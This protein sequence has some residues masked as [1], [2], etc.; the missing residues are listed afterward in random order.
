VRVLTWDEQDFILGLLRG[1]AVRCAEGVASAQGLPHAREGF[2]ADRDMANDLA[3][4]F[5]D[6]AQDIRTPDRPRPEVRQRPEVVR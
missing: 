6:L 2:K 3:G 5:S 1:A 4:L